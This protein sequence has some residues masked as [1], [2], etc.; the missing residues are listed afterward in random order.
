[1]NEESDNVDILNTID[2]INACNSEN[3]L[4]VAESL[5][6]Y[7]DKLL[8]IMEYSDQPLDQTLSIFQEGKIMDDVK[9][10]G[11]G[12]SGVQKVFTFLFRFIKSVI[13]AI[14]G[15]LS[16]QSTKVSKPDIV[17]KNPKLKSALETAK[18]VVK[19][20]GVPVLLVGGTYVTIEEYLN[21]DRMSLKERARNIINIKEHFSNIKWDQEI[22]K[23]E[24][25]NKEMLSS[26]AGIDLIKKINF[27]AIIKP[28]TWGIK[29]SGEIIYTDGFENILFAYN[30]L[31]DGARNFLFNTSYLGIG[32][33]IK[34]TTDPVES[35]RLTIRS[36][37][38]KAVRDLKSSIN[39]VY[40][41]LVEKHRE[42]ISGK[43]LEFAGDQFK[44]AE[45]KI[46]ENDTKFKEFG[47]EELQ[48]FKD[49]YNPS[50]KMLNDMAITVR[51]YYNDLNKT[52]N[53]I[54]GILVEWK[55]AIMDKFAEIEKSM[56]INMPK[57]TDE[58]LAQI[59]GVKKFKS[60]DDK[61]DDEKPSK[62]DAKPEDKE[63]ADKKEDDEKPEKESKE[64]KKDD[65]KKD[66]KEE[67]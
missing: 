20:V 31:V 55:K 28:V 46:A 62:S 47:E 56:S 49:N 66:E 16:T 38:L 53:E 59:E 29:P 63:K 42:D 21:H 54:N 17:E 44:I 22:S 45:H 3:E 6:M 18:G 48:A 40:R 57:L 15:K 24:K 23:Y 25:E 52:F 36:I 5:V 7:Y 60:S 9:K 14:R 1:M 11:E 64:E 35:I 12:Q 37:K 67:K 34:D 26:F 41:L 30:R 65:D 13:K 10:Q 51:E 2:E 50:D 27:D 32:S 39:L 19:A 33:F 61:K 43:D 58:A 8:S 4:C